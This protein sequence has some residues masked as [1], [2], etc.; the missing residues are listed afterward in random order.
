M[1][2]NGEFNMHHG[3]P[4]NF[5]VTSLRQVEYTFPTYTIGEAATATIVSG[6]ACMLSGGR[7]SIRAGKGRGERA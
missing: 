4:D 3:L 7:V 1:I 6:S 5:K 2:V